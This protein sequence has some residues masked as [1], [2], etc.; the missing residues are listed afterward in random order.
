M[1]SDLSVGQLAVE[2]WLKIAIFYVLLMSSIR[3]EADLKIL[4]AAFLVSIFLYMAHSLREYGNGRNVWRQGTARMVGVDQSFNDPNTFAATIAYALPMVLPFWAVS[5]K[6]WVRNA[7]IGYIGLSVVCIGLTGS[8]TGFLIL[9][10]LGLITI[11]RS[12]RKVL[13]LSFVSI[14]A[15]LLFLLLPA[16]RQDRYLTIIDLS[17]GPENSQKVRDVSQSVFRKIG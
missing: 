14:A 12:K 3:N 9:S 13:G 15:P 5:R 8:R 4:V 6:R 17:R 10:A 7:I 1:Q 16:D 11:W 2:N